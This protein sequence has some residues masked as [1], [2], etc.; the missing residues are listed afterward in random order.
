[1]ADLNRVTLIGRLTRD[2]ELVTAG[3]FIISKFSVAVNRRVKRGDGWEDEAGFFDVTLFGRQAESLN[4]YLLKG[5]QVAVD[6]ELRQ[7]RWTTQDGR[8]RSRIVINAAD[9]QL[10]G[11]N[12]GSER[13][14]QNR[15]PA[16]GQGR[17]DGKFADDIPF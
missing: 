16:Q 7:E 3:G 17:F 12:G 14:S 13:P 1:M 2:A 6:G 10:L 11:V 9:I 8:N 15:A 5:K 4:Q